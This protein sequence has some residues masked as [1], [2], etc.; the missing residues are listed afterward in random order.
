MACSPRTPKTDAPY[1]PGWEP[2]L[3]AINADLD[4]DTVRLAFADW[5]QENG[6]E[7]RAAFIRVQVALYRT[8]EDASPEL[9]ARERQLINDNRG[10]WTRGLP[11]ELTESSWSFR[12]GFVFSASATARQWL[13]HGAELRRL[14][15][16]E[17]LGLSRT[18]D[19]EQVFAQ[20]SLVGLRRLFLDDPR[21]TCFA[22][23]ADAPALDSL[24][25]LAIGDCAS[26]SGA[27]RGP[28]A[29]LARS[30]RLANLARVCLRS[31]PI[32]DSFAHGLATN[33]AVRKL[34]EAEFLKTELSAPWFE[35]FVN[36]PAAVG[37]RVLNLQANYFGDDGCRRLV[38]SPLMELDELNLR[39]T[40]LT[41]ESARLLAAWPGL[42]SV[43]T[44][45]LSGNEFG[46][47]GARVLLTSE[48]LANL[49]ALELP[50]LRIHKPDRE[51][52]AALPEYQRIPRVTFA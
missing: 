11:P 45:R 14:T 52:L 44:L 40:N 4:D 42:K 47:D 39:Y 22:A 18:V 51:R 6:D 26:S 5:L 25:G 9:R 15:P 32:G 31:S 35:Q 29:V 24:T 33:S 1:P 7:A 43:R 34:L 10:R 46:P 23:L 2:F 48:H 38:N 49:T 41:A 19:C 17:N 36:S 16:L 28:A 21:P 20:P 37:L 8:D 12:R 13:R 30:P 27:I 50:T 3:A